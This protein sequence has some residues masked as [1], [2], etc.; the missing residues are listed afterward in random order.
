MVV[1][2]GDCPMG[3]C[4]FE[5]LVTMRCA[6]SRVLQAFDACAPATPMGVIAG[7]AS[8]SP[9]ILLLRSPRFLVHRAPTVPG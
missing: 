6:L 1:G 7:S 9:A 5:V 3:R 2:T 8:G 4:G